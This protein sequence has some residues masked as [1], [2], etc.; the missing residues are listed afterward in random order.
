MTPDINALLLECRRFVLERAWAGCSSEKE[1]T[2]C[3][4]K[5][6]AFLAADMVAVP[7][8]PT[9]EMVKGGADIIVR[10][11]VNKTGVGATARNVYWHMIAAAE[12][13]G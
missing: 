4:E 6:D 1:A 8:E 5:L 11:E 3:L 7:R 9:F 12:G 13:E 2:A 10:A